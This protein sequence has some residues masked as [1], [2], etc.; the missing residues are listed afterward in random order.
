MQSG[1]ETWLVYA[2]LKEKFY[3]KILQKMWPGN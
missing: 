3:Q 2:I 1:N